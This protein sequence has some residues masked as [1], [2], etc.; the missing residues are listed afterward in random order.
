MHDAPG[1]F[2]DAALK[3]DRNEDVVVCFK[4]MPGGFTNVI[5]NVAKPL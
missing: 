5:D 4:P 1:S 3:I 2:L